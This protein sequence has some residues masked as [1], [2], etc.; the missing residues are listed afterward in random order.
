MVPGLTLLA[1]EA[2]GGL[3]PFVYGL[4]AFAILMALLF[5]TIGI[6]KGRPHSK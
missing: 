1:T 4:V 6:G 2:E 5:I 3:P